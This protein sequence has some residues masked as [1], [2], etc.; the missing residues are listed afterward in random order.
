MNRQPKKWIL[1]CTVFLFL[2]VISVNAWAA[3][4]KDKIQAGIE[5]NFDVQVLKISKGKDMGRTV[6]FVKVMFKGGNYNTAFQVNTL[7][8]DAGTGKPLPQFRH[9]PSGRQLSGA[10]N[11]SPNR[12]PPGALRGHIWR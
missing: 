8:I 5:K 3:M 7:V 12:Q 11:Y 10:F 1:S 9:G 2:F 4:S 6:F